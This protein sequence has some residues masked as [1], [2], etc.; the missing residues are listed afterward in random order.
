MNRTISIRFDLTDWEFRLKKTK[1]GK[2]LNVGP[3][4]ISYINHEILNSYVQD[5]LKSIEKDLD[6][7]NIKESSVVEFKTMTKNNDLLN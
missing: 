5:L 4:Q 7:H 6:D 1:S 2:T 3:L